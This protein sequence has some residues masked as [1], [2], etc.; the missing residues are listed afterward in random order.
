MSLKIYEYGATV[1]RYWQNKTVDLGENL[2]Q[3][4]FDHHRSYVV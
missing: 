2:S 3:C 1:E 4:H